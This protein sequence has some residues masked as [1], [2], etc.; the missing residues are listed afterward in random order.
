MSATAGVLHLP[1][2]RERVGKIGR[3]GGRLRP[4]QLQPL[5]VGDR[6]AQA[7]MQIPGVVLCSR[8]PVSERAEVRKACGP[9]RVLLSKSP[10]THLPMTERTIDFS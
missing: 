10:A 7:G 6:A 3:G 5:A 4:D 2:A 9:R 8:R 1:L